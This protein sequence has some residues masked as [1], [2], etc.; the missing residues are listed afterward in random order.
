MGNCQAID[1]AVLV[2]QHPSGKIERL[3][4]PINASDVMNMNPGHYV[5][6]I[7]PLPEQTT[8]ERRNAKPVQFTQVKLLKPNE[9][10]ALGHAY[11]LIATQGKYIQ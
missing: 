2:I 1:A 5:S 7:I 4:W 9:T 6:L 8:E 10:L 3:Y 11:R